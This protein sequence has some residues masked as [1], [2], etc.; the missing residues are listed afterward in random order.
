[1]MMCRDVALAMTDAQE[2]KLGGLRKLL[3]RFHMS[4]CPHCQAH[5]KQLETTVAT[6]NALPKEPPAEDAREK[7]L[8]AFRKNRKEG[9]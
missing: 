3:Y 1:M 7:A 8:A 6:L 5:E 2:G 4:V 9:V